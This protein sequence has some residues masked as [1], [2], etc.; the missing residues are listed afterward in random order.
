MAERE[1]RRLSD[2]I[3]TLEGRSPAYSGPT[4]S[5]G[6][7]GFP[8]PYQAPPP[9]TRDTEVHPGVEDAWR[10]Y[11]ELQRQYEEIRRSPAPTPPAAPVVPKPSRF[12]RK[13]TAP[14]PRPAAPPIDTRFQDLQYALEGARQRLTDAL[15]ARDHPAQPATVDRD[16]AEY[17]ERCAELKANAERLAELRAQLVEQERLV[18]HHRLGLSQWVID[19][20]RREERIDLDAL[21]AAR[22]AGEAEA[23]QAR[24]RVAGFAAAG[25][26]PDQPSGLA[27]A[28]ALVERLRGLDQVLT[29]AALL[30]GQAR[31]EAREAAR[32]GVQRHL[33]SILPDL[34]EE[35][36]HQVEVTERLEV[37]L[38]RLRD[39]KV[40]PGP[41]STVDEYGVLSRVALGYDLIGDREL[42]PLLLDDVTS[43]GDPG[44]TRRLLDRLYQSAANQQIV[45]FA[46]D[47]VTR[48]WAR[49]RMATHP[50]LQLFD[51]TSV[52]QPPTPA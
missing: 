10:A 35:A 29:T 5:Y 2:E 21:R 39:G 52:D 3:D 41:R 16:V 38:I 33:R 28:K 31:A 48:D 14:A 4:P 27:E 11:L 51:I 44:R 25:S 50:R 46:H 22:E 36:T 7:I 17:R 40:V 30:L 15:V 43:T 32:L 34:T 42:P 9:S 23:S 24:A 18:Q 20:V 26:G 12:G 13:E 19:A 37:R 6:S 8:P 45:L 47:Q 1:V 49:E